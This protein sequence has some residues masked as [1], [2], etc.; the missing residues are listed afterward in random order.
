VFVC[1]CVTSELRR[2]RALLD[3]Y[4]LYDPTMALNQPHG[5]EPMES[6]T[7]TNDRFSTRP[8]TVHDETV[9]AAEAATASAS[10]PSAVAVGNS[11]RLDDDKSSASASASSPSKQ[12]TSRH[13]HDPHRPHHLLGSERLQARLDSY[14]LATTQGGDDPQEPPTS[15]FASASASASAPAS[16]V[17]SAGRF[18]HQSPQQPQMV[19]GARV[20]LTHPAPPNYQL[21]ERSQKSST[22]SMNDHHC[23]YNNHLRQQQHQRGQH[24]GIS[25]GAYAMPWNGMTMGGDDRGVTDDPTFAWTT[26]LPTTV[27]G[28]PTSTITTSLFGWKRPTLQLISIVLLLFIVVFAATVTAVSLTSTPNN[29]NSNRVEPND[30]TTENTTS[31]SSTSVVLNGEDLYLALLPLLEQTTLNVS[32]LLDSGSPQSKAAQWLA[33][34][35]RVTATLWTTGIFGSDRITQRYILAVLYFSTN[36][37]SGSGSSG[38]DQEVNEEE[39]EYNNGSSFSSSTWRERYNFLSPLLDECNWTTT[40]TSKVL[41]PQYGGRQAGVSCNRQNHVT[42]IVLGAFQ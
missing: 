20:G 29:T 24:F 22:T 33:Y 34:D 37:G 4:V 18:W 40:T 8:A 41:E 11:G 39:K 31:S 12:E 32:V 5:T 17:E 13:D 27:D 1:V 42:S 30:S 15:S 25:P 16:A 28:T 26:T 3:D 6:A 21:R 14:S 23:H 38:G 2:R 10:S 36:G 9:V 7:S 35:D 19:E